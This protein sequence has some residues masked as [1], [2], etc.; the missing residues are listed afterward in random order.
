MI[1]HEFC[2][3]NKGFT[4]LINTICHI[5][6]VHCYRELKLIIEP[7]IPMGGK[8]M[9]LYLKVNNAI[10]DRILKS[11]VFD[12]LIL[13]PRKGSYK[14]RKII[15]EFPFDSDTQMINICGE[16]CKI[17]K[18]EKELYRVVEEIYYEYNGKE[19]FTC[20]DLYDGKIKIFHPKV[21]EI[22]ADEEN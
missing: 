3:L 17:R 22:N 7:E 2:F 10:H 12:K 15:Y 5:Q 18:L 20:L 16:E 11:K 14:N 8:L 9:N 13:T 1:S 4:E 6:I 21:K 19:E